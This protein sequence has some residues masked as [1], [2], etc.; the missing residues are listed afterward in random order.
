MKLIVM[1]SLV[2]SG[3]RRDFQ[4]FLVMEEMDTDDVKIFVIEKQHEAAQYTVLLAIRAVVGE[5]LFKGFLAG[6]LLITNMGMQ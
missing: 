2:Q 4:V 1:Q 5:V 6:H 3:S